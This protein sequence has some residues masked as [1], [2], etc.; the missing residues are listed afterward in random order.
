MR[1]QPFGH[2][3]ATSAAEATAN[4]MSEER[5]STADGVTV[6]LAAANP[7]VLACIR[8]SPLA[9]LGQEPL[10]F[11]ARAVITKYQDRVAAKV[12]HGEG[13]VRG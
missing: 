8:A 9:E 13:S 1:L 12:T 5:S 2:Q 6:W 7:S 10:L 4:V 11:N 3:R